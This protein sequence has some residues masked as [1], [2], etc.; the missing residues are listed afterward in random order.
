[1]K[2]NKTNINEILHSDIIIS[3]R[4]IDVEGQKIINEQSSDQELRKLIP[5]NV[6]AEQSLLEKCIASNEALF[7]IKYWQEQSFLVILVPFSLYDVNLVGE[8]ILKMNENI[9]I[10]SIPVWHKP[11]D[12]LKKISLLAVTDELTGLYNRR[13][14]NMA[15]P[16]EIINAAQKGRPLSVVFADLDYFK[17]T[18]DNYGH[19][20]GDHVLKELSEEMKKHIR[21]N[22]DWIARYGGDE[23]LFCLNN[24]DRSRAGE[25]I[26][27]I[28]QNIENKV[29]KYG[30][31]QIK[32]TCS[33]G[34]YTIRDFSRPLT[35]ETILAAID[36]NL[37]LAKQKRN[38]VI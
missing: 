16:A 22:N 10:D 1:M 4:F 13:Y 32:L 30:N 12:T 15:L 9:R 23:F 34:I 14:I 26:E 38:C 19:V 2:T 27:R 17:A 25:I 20:V 35:I 11:I 21:K 6:Q 18:N 33:F 5:C 8:F 36:K 24:A 31:H 28:R 37:Y 7:H 29:F 3:T